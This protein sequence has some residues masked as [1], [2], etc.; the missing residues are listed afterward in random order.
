MHQKIIDALDGSCYIFGSISAKEISTKSSVSCELSL[1][2]AI[3]DFVYLN[4][5]VFTFELTWAE[6]FCFKSS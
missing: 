2:C 3:S 1:S 4:N 5:S 6:T